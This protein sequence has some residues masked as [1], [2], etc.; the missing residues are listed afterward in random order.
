MVIEH[1]PFSIGS[2]IFSAIKTLAV[3]ASEK[4][5]N[6]VYEVEEYVPDFVVGDAFRL[7]QVIL[8]LLGNAIKFTEH[9]EIRVAVKKG[10]G[11]TVHADENAFEISVS[12]T[13]IGISTDKLDVIFEKFRQADGSTARRFGGTGLGLAIS[14]KIANLMGGDIAVTSAVGIGSTFSSLLS[15]SSLIHR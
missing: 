9:G 3:E 1:V 11:N 10:L 4:I 2:T 14:K 6:L 8:N 12:D 5:I 13:G 7:R 15:Q